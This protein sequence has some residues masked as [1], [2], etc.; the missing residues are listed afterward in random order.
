LGVARGLR[1]LG[2]MSEPKARARIDM[3]DELE[4]RTRELERTNQELRETQA[5]LIQAEKLPAMGTFVAGVAHE[6]NNPLAFMK[7]GVALIAD[8]ARDVSSGRASDSRKTIDEIPDICTEVLAGIS[9]LSRIAEELRDILGTQEVAVEEVN[10]HEE[11]LHAWALACR[12]T[13]G[14]PELVV[15]IDLEAHWTT[16][17]RPLRQALA[18]VLTNAAEAAPQG[19]RVE[20]SS[21]QSAEELRLAIRDDGPGILPAHLG[22]IFDPFF[23]TKPP[24]AGLGLSVA[25]ALSRNLGGSPSASSEPGKGASFVLSLPRSPPRSSL[26]SKCLPRLGREALGRT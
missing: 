9:R 11:V 14:R 6:L 23:T 1:C 19:G 7:S 21:S 13:E 15:S 12:R 25:L 24:A 16:V 2:G 4:Q 17:R 3:C 5:A 18:N 10:V 8:L 26:I 20:V 22:R